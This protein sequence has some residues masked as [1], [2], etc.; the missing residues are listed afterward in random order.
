MPK[1]STRP[2]LT[3]TE[4]FFDKIVKNFWD[5]AKPNLNID[6]CETGIINSVLKS[7]LTKNI[8]KI[9]KDYKI[10]KIGKTGDPYIRSDKKDYRNG[11]N[12]M[13]I[14]YKSTSEKNIS[15]IEEEYIEKFMNLEP[16]KIQNKRINAPGKKMQSYD[17]YYYL[18]LVTN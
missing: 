1:K 13:F 3:E 10:F 9:I 6:F 4:T 18:Y 8:N 5:G 11:Y 16:N 7:K 2:H 17:G 12:H 14:I 15:A